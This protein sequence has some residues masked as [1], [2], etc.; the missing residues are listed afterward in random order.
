MSYAV[1]PL[2]DY[3]STCDKVREK[4]DLTTV[5]FEDTDFGYIRSAKFTAK[6][7][8]EYVFTVG[9]KDESKL[10]IYGIYHAIPEWEDNSSP[11]VFNVIDEKTLSAYFYKDRTA[12]IFISDYKGLKASDIIFAT[13]SYNGEV[14]ENFVGPQKIKSGELADKVDEVYEAGKE[15]GLEEG[16]EAGAEYFGTEIQKEGIGAVIL[17]GIPPLERN[18]NVQLR[19]MNLWNPSETVSGYIHSDGTILP[20]SAP[21]LHL[22]SDFIPCTPSQTY[23]MQSTLTTLSSGGYQ[24]CGI[25]FYD[26]NKNFISLFESTG[27]PN[28]LDTHYLTAKAP[29]NAAYVRGSARTHGHDNAKLMLSISD[30]VCE[31]VP[32]VADL[33]GIEVKVS[34]ESQ[35]EPIAYISD[36]YG[37]VTAKSISPRMTIYT[38]NADV[39]LQVTYLATGDCKF[40][41]VYQIG[42]K[43]TDY[44]RFGTGTTMG[45]GLTPKEQWWTD[46]NFNPIYPLTIE[47][48]QE[49][50]GSNVVL[51][52]TKVPIVLVGTQMNYAFGGAKSLKTIRSLDITKCTSWVS[53]FYLCYAL[54]NITFVGTVSVDISFNYSKKLTHESLMSIINAL[55]D[56]SSDTSGK[57]HKVN[58]GSEN[59]AKLTE[60]EKAI[61]TQ[62]GWTYS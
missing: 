22:T 24:W 61:I 37:V 47:N 20:A 60:E 3:V 13:L 44:Y 28:V 50:F 33:S 5:R 2:D 7:S 49:L 32:Y 16:Q 11:G 40:W 21:G 38:E 30:T 42:G 62:K 25:G 9:V 23:T 53:P 34:S 45:D 35:P 54:E 27:K 36:T 18:V 57:T 4:V 10:N 29:N 1:M 55:Y 58:L 26:S 14:V 56:F 46:E 51:T 39:A 12:R 43:R 6:E 59:L 17:S 52:D 19:S 15:A 8:G 31:Y 41:E 48:G